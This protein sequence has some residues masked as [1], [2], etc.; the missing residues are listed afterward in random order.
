[1]LA[2][3]LAIVAALAAFSSGTAQAQSAPAVPLFAGWN[4]V[5][6][7]GIPL[8]LPDALNN[9]R[10]TVPTVWKLDAPSQQWQV[11]SANIPASLSSLSSVSPGDVLFVHAASA[12]TW[13]QPLTPP[14]PAPTSQP[15]LWEITFSRT[16]ILFNFEESI[17]FDENGLGT[18]TNTQG[19]A[20]AVLVN[21]GSLAGV[22]ATLDTNGFF[23]SAT[24]DTRSG[25]TSCF[26]YTIVVRAPDGSSITLNTDGAGVSG[27]LQRLVNQL[28]AILI[29]SLP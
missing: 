22:D 26:H 12:I 17:T 27:A 8:P 10:G 21:V 7:Q 19:T 1:M 23:A 24:P 3:A 25:C 4:N 28:T 20:A 18:V 16:T 6:Y 9:V 11:W 5:A 2:T 13:M 15:T 29:T 14:P